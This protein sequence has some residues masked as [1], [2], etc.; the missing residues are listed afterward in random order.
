MVSSRV[1]IRKARKQREI[2]NRKAMIAFI[3]HGAFGLL[4][5]LAFNE[6]CESGFNMIKNPSIVN[7]FLG[8]ATLGIA[9]VAFVKAIIEL[10]KLN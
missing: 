7:I 10:S 2:A 4:N 3:S 1:E 8:L 5:S 9:S 6:L